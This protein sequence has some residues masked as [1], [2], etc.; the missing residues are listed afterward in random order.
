MPRR[1][2][3][4]VAGVAHHV[5]QRGN[6]REQVFF[7]DKDYRKYLS[8]LDCHASRAGTLVLGYCLMPNH[9][10]LVVV[11]Q[12]ED[13]LAR[14]LG[15][16]HS[17]YA[18]AVNRTAGRSGHLWQNRFFSCP[19]DER[20]LLRALRYTDLNPMRAG[21]V[22]DP[23]AWHWSSA[24]AHGDAGARD[25]RLKAG[26]VDYFRSWDHNEWREVLEAEM[27]A[28]E[29]ESIR[30]ATLTGAPLG[31]TEFVA[32]LENGAGRRLRVYARGRPRRM[33]KVTQEPVVREMLF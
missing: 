24:R 26:W 30:L 8:L 23:L 33:E 31:S 4:V 6:N 9:I 16:L 20:H 19:L 22:T 1:A 25:E 11:P 7:S 32:D 17:E 12:T 29:V 14:T 5:T 15:P 18:L 21:L 2:R 3:I 10:H 13:S 28:A 27:A